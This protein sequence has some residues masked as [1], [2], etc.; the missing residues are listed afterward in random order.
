[1]TG[2]TV[3][4]YEILERLGSGGMGDIFR[5][6]DTRL[7]RMVAIKV[8][9]KSESGDETPRL[10]FIQEARAASGLSHPNIVTVH[11][12]L[13]DDE[14]DLLVM[15]LVPGKTIAQMVPA[16]G[17]PIPQALKYAVQI[18]SALAAA[19][20]AGIVHR[21]VKPA[22]VMVTG[23]GLVK[24]LD[25]G[26][27]K[28]TYTVLA[29]DSARTASISGPVTVKGTVV[30]TVNYMS[31]EQAEG[32]PVDGRSDVFSFGILLYEM[33]TGHR[34]FPGESAIATMTAIL[35]DEVRPIREFAP[36]APVRLHEIVEKCLRKNRDERWQT[37]DELL[38]ALESLKLQYDTGS[39]PTVLV[40]VAPEKSR[41]MLVVAVLAIAAAVAV[42]GGATW[43]A[44][45]RRRAPQPA[46]SQPEASAQAP[47]QDTAAPAASTGSAAAPAPAPNPAM[48]PA[49]TAASAPLTND[50]IVQMLEA[51]VP[52]AVIL[53]QIRSSKT[54]FDFSTAEVIRL[55]HA[56]APESLIQAM[57]DASGPAVAKPAAA[58]PA[59]V[60]PAD[61]TT[62]AA[63]STPAGEA[64]ANSPAPVPPAPQPAGH[65]ERAAKTIV[66]SDAAQ[67]VVELSA[68]IPLDAPAATPLK[69]TVVKDVVAGDCVV[70]S[71]GALAAGH[72][73]DE[74]RKRVLVLETKMTF[75]LEQV[76]AVGGQ[77]LKLRATPN[78][79]SGRRAVDSGTYPGAKKKPKDLAAVAGTRYVVYIDGSQ[80]IAVRK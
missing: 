56:G 36:A 67:V 33:V 49:P 4:H 46:P 44:V 66:V 64:A 21:D 14:T 69:F 57:R 9:P 28:P 25:F 47:G 51:K 61:A 26:L 22:N 74:A 42:A 8:L 65:A 16:T 13:A 40:P 70:I 73:V 48:P 79:G 19:H 55:S 18:A 78:P 68:G 59:P 1:M 7:S 32:K 3:S 35:R 6:R 27:A 63:D 10:R 37:M 77:K 38:A 50:S 54:Q 39:A 71:K 52:I 76:D 45:A 12:I 58:A 30:G 53:G 2:R 29:D 43:W 41:R 15:E 5:A 72:V 24:V 75:Q 17:F 62:P 34:A 31:P 23:S 20:A 11:D 80:P 60:K